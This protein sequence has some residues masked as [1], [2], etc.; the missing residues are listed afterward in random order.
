ARRAA[1]RLARRSPARR[2]GGRGARRPAALYPR[3]AALLHHE[4]AAPAE[5]YVPA[6][7]GEAAAG[8][9]RTVTT[10]TAARTVV[11][12]AKGAARWQAGHPWIYRTDVYD[13]PRDEPGIVAVTDRRGR[14]LGQALYSPRSEIRLRLL[15]RGRESID[16]AWWGE[17]IAARAARRAGIATTAYRVVHAEGDGLP[18]LVVDRYGPYVVAQLLSAGLEQ[19]RDDVLA[20]IG[21]ALAPEGILLRNDSAIRRHEGLPLEVTLAYGEVPKVVEV[22]EGDVRY[23]AAPWTGQKT[24]A[25]LD[26]RENRQLVGEHAGRAGG[27][28]LDL[29]TYHGSF[30]LHLARRAAAVVAVDTSAEALARGRENATLN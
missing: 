4:A 25:F 12:S 9:W 29:F 11:V 7:G 17:R 10:L 1:A 18:S 27:R 21:A 24:G 23:A 8:S 6:R 5:T 26:Q 16:A 14:H 28:A 20:G 22:V 15:T 19:V 30:A 3:A 13:E 2:R